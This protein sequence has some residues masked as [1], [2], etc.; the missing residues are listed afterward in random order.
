MYDLVLADGKT[1][2]NTRGCYAE[3]KCGG[4][5]DTD[6]NSSDSMFWFD[7]DRSENLSIAV[8][9]LPGLRGPEGPQGNTF[10]MVTV[11]MNLLCLF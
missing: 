2:K 10:A 8:Q 1:S 6:M 5:Q 7:V 4:E 3:L 11:P 9:G